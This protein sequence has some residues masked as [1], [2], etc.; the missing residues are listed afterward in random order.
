MARRGTEAFPELGAHC[1]REDCNQLDFLPFDCDGC[2]KVFCAEHRTYRGHGCARAADQGRT[3]VVCE[4]CGD[5]IE[6]PAAAGGGREKTD[7]E[8]LEA[9]ARSRRG[10]DPARKRKPRCPAPRCKE[11][12]TFSNTSECKGCGQKLCLRHRFPAD[13]ACARVSPAGAAA[14]A[15]RKGAGACARDA[16]KK[17]GG[18]TLP[19]LIRN[20]KMF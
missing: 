20:L 2:G 13:H 6:R 15:R 17:D 7:A 14:A 19:P 1:D 10:C 8:I 11:T 12:L 5:A 4:A 9:H 16:Q 18:W 3:V